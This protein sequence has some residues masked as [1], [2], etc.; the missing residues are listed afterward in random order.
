MHFIR[1]KTPAWAIQIARATTSHVSCQFNQALRSKGALIEVRGL[2]GVS[3]KDTFF[4]SVRERNMDGEKDED[5]QRLSSAQALENE[6]LNFDSSQAVVNSAVTEGETAN[7]QR[8]FDAARE[9]F[10][11]IPTALRMMPKMDPCGV[12]AN[13]NLRLDQLE[14]YGFDYDYTLIH[15]SG[16]LQTLIYDLAK[17]HIVKEHRYPESCLQFQYDPE[18]PIRG[19]FYDKKNGCL[20]KLDFFHNIEPDGCYYG[21]RKMSR[22]E[23]ERI[24]GS[25]HIS[26]DYASNLVGL[27]DLFCFS[28]AC[29]ISDIIQHF[30]DARL[31]FDA[32]YVLEDVK[33]AIGYVHQSGLVH[34][35]ILA[36]PD[37]YLVKNAAVLKFLRTLRERGK[38]LFLLTNSPFYF[39]DRGMRYMFQD[40]GLNGDSWLDLFEVV[41]ALSDKPNFYTSD[42]PFRR[43]DMEKDIV[44]FSK[45]NAFQPH[46][47]YY[48]GCLKSFLEI[49]K[50][51]GSEVI[52]FGDHL[53]S[54]LR[55]PIK[56]GWRTAAI[57][58]ELEKEI[59]TQ[60]EDK[61]RFQQAKFHIVQEFLAKFHSLL[62]NKPR[63]DADNAL[64]NALNEERQKSR[65]AMKAMF[66]PYFGAAFLTDTGRES[67][68]AYNIQRYADVYTS[69][70]EN[71]LNYSSE[72]WLDPPYDVKI[73]PHHVKIPSSVLKTKAHQDG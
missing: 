11:N 9:S 18:F 36:E 34:R 41:I 38:K 17:E 71:F 16:N 37:K 63:N 21:R 57:I 14:V 39:V 6:M 60:N 46:T 1:R 15:Y 30:V 54:D 3:S 2:H 47:V 28:E 23:L 13:D 69:R 64:L 62:R 51:K 19:L 33:R 24:Y 35:T 22:E 25:R 70:L 73:M 66:N 32:C 40:F 26:R 45:V 65:C 49:T 44:T 10:Q 20:L 61:Y 5:C 59:T 50:W 29:L 8:E 31:D 27:M 56:A 42:R 4:G 52:Y 58:K 67:A 55:G 12:Y 7:L 48:H 43:Y 72:A 53:F 68:F